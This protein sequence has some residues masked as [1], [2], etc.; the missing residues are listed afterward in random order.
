MQDTNTNTADEDD[1]S[2]LPKK[3]DI[4]RFKLKRNE[5]A[6]GVSGVG[7]V[8][9]GVRFSD[10]TTILKWTSETPCTS[11]FRSP[12]ELIHVH[13]HSGLTEIVWLDP[14]F[15]EEDHQA[16]EQAEKQKNKSATKKKKPVLKKK[17]K[18]K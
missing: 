9:E 17:K 13:G 14:E 10:G 7:I 1:L 2:N 8:A 16:A 15:E 12:V 11:I 6:S 5:D 4:R 3:T 18:N